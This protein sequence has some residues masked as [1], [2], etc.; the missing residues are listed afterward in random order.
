VIN[1]RR[2]AARFT[3][4][5][6]LAGFFLYA[7]FPLYY[8]V[9]SSLQQGSQL[10]E[11]TYLPRSANLENYVAV[12]GE[13][14]FGRSILNSFAVGLGTVAVTLFL[15]TLAAYALGRIRFRGRRSVLF[16]FLTVSMFPQVA[17]LSGMFELIRWLGLYN[18]LPALVLSY[19][20]LTLPFSIWVLTAFMR[21]L[22]TEIEEA[23]ILDGASRWTIL[24]R[25]LAPLAAPAIVTTG[26]LALI[27]AW[28]EFLF[29]LTFS[30]GP[31]SR[32]VPV[33][34]AL[35]SGASQH[36]LPWGVLMAA[37]VVVAV[38]LVAIV[39]VFQGRIVSGL[40]TGALKG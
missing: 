10:F 22:P 20:V 17:V 12:F 30:L 9:I 35:I 33:A 37:S 27:I 3:F 19:L 1:T 21:E 24:T 4:M 11:P 16:A 2:I 8:A 32:T 26:L 36:E 39:L 13:Q 18:T 40:T 6:L 31:E 25:I 23:A 15:A 7:A 28:N 38:P 34:I 29:A 5:L 14:P